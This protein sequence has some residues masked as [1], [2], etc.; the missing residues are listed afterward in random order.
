MQM[1]I[2]ILE[3]DNPNSLFRLPTDSRYINALFAGALLEAMFLASAHTYHAA[4]MNVYGVIVYIIKKYSYI[5]LGLSCM[6][7]SS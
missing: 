5:R 7:S 4:K 1:R 2:T 3:I 6:K